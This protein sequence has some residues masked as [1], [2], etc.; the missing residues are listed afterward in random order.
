MNIFKL[1]LFVFV[2]AFSVQTFAAEQCE[3]NFSSAGSFFKGK[4]FKTWAD[5]PGVDSVNAYKK[6][7]LQ[8]VK[9]GWKINSS[10]KELGI[11]SAGQE[12]SYG[13]G[14]S[15]PLSITVEKIGE[16]NSKISIAYSI[17]GGISAAEKDVIKSFCQTIASA[18]AK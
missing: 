9:D 18:S 7:Y 2:G 16:G 15:A 6:V 3:T 5:V 11:I 8:V 14:K 10:D 4:V 17:S 1:S 12:V 13:A